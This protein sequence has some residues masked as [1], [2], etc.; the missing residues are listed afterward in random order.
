MNSTTR[1]YILSQFGEHTKNTNDIIVS[2][3]KFSINGE[4][5]ASAKV[6]LG[7]AMSQEKFLSINNF[8]LILQEIL[9]S[10]LFNDDKGNHIV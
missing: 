10:V 3:R 7:L 1:N 9:L 5:L 4:I 2:E 8:I 6:N